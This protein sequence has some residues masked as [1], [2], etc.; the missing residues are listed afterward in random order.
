MLGSLNEL[1]IYITVGVDVLT[2]EDAIEF[3]WNKGAKVEKGN[4]MKWFDMDL[5]AVKAAGKHVKLTFTNHTDSLVWAATMVSVEC[6]AK[7]TM[8]LLVPVPAGMSIDHVINYQLFAVADLHNIYIGVLTDG[9]LELKAESIDATILPP[10]DCLSAQKIVSGQEYVQ[11]AGSQWYQFPMSLI[12]EMGGATKIS[13]KNLTSNHATLS[14]GVSV[15]CE[16]PVN[17]VAKAKA[18]RNIEF[19]LNIPKS[20][21]LLISFNNNLVGKCFIIATVNIIEIFL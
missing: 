8:P 20:I 13:F 15:G 1:Y 7:L 2:C 10:A 4:G 9:A 19:S 18:L 17:T 12:D 3:D 11:N 21:I 6:P 5:D 14:A 16:Y